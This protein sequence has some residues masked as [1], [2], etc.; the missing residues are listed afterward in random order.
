VNSTTNANGEKVCRY[1]RQPP[2][3]ID[4]NS[5]AWLT[6]AFVPH[7]EEAYV[8]LMEMGL[9]HKEHSYLYEPDHWVLHESLAAGKWNYRSSSDE[10]FL[11]SIP[12]VSAITRSSTNV[13]ICDG[14][15][16]VSYQL[17]YIGGKEEHQLVDVAGS[18][19]ITEVNITTEEHQHEKI[20]NC[21]Q[22]AKHKEKKNAHLS[23]EMSL[24]EVVWFN[25][26]FPYT[27]CTAEFIHVP[28]LPIESRAV[29]LLRQNTVKISL[30]MSIT[31][32]YRLR[33]NLMLQCS[34]HVAISCY[35]QPSFPL[36]KAAK[37]L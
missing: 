32:S 21:A 14:H 8:L 37:T 2:L 15:F 27:Y 28:A 11:A 6:P 33:C 19:V 23:R 25:L 36:K 12:L 16:Q 34:N 5:C 22:I 35:K 3:P 31:L 17:K 9:A 26:G 10:F 4:G 7:P 29:V 18:K 13:E 20:T 24:A 1:H 30:V